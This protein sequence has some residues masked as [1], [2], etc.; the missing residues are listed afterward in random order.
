[1]AL[2]IEPTPE[3]TGEDAKRFMEQ[4]DREPTKLEIQTYKRALKFYKEHK[5]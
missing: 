3:L 4:L 1:M 5:L 2:P